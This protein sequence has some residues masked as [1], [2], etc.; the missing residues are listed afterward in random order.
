MKAFMTLF[1]RQLGLFFNTWKQK[2]KI[3]KV[4]ID[5]SFKVKLIKLYRQKLQKCFDLWRI[6]RSNLVIEMQAME[7]EEIQAQNHEIEVACRE[8]ELKN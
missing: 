6:K 3:T 4:S 5:G 7:C 1:G 8:R 2:A